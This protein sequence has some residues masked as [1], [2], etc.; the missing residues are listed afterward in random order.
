MTM[1]NMISAFLLILLIFPFLLT[2]SQS[3]GDYSEYGKLVKIPLSSAP[4][5]HPLR[6]SGHT[7]NGKEYPADIHY[8][9]STVA[10][11]IPN[12]FNPE[13]TTDFVFYFH[14]WYNNIDTALALF[15]I[16][17]QFTESGKNAILIFPEGPRNS[18]DSFG[19]KLE[20]SLG[21][22]ILMN[23]ILEYLSHTNT[24]HGKNIGSIVLSGHSGAYRI[25]SSIIMVGGL[26]PFIK[27]VY[28]F[29]ALYDRLAVFTQWII[30][31]KG[32]FINIFTPEGGTKDMSL[33]MIEDLTDWNAPPL[34][35]IESAVDED[36]L[37]NNKVIFIDSPLEHNDVIAK[38]KQFFYYLKTSS[39]MNI[40]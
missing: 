28:L 7:Y 15:N 29:D 34:L 9:D 6:S 30:E 32:R 5:P 22:Q 16:T 20:D 13:K 4:F 24:I 33:L 3:A 14:G 17:E 19:G 40:Q 36:I 1:K 23:D 27:E 11:F 37:M 35:I 18:P 2:F 10:I 39:L 21:F 8:S 31:S 12:G 25:I 38:N 26:T